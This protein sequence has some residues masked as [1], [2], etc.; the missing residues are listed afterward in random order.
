MGMCCLFP[1]E[2]F[3]RNDFVGN[4]VQG[5]DLSELLTTQP[6]DIRSIRGMWE[7]LLLIRKNT[8]SERAVLLDHRSHELYYSPYGFAHLNDRAEAVRYAAI[9]NSLVQPIDSLLTHSHLYEWA[10]DHQGIVLHSN[11]D[12]ES[13]LA[14][15]FGGRDIVRFCLRGLPT[16]R[17]SLD[18]QRVVDRIWTIVDAVKW[19]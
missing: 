14:L 1:E 18:F 11:A 3:E 4:P 2:F 9:G 5:A 17:H 10:A 16:D 8:Q 12:C 6:S 13:T 15:E 19:Q 7:K